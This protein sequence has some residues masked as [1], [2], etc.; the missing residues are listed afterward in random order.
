[1]YE[2]MHSSI[3]YSM[4]FWKT[5]SRKSRFLFIKK[6]SKIKKNRGKQVRVEN[7]KYFLVLS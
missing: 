1:M 7:L 3:A 2:K 6:D 4:Q 5:N